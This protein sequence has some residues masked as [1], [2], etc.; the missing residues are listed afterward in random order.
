MIENIKEIIEEIRTHGVKG[1][2][3]FLVG[4]FLSFSPLLAAV[5]LAP[6]IAKAAPEVVRGTREAVKEAKELAREIRS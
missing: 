2:G 5:V 1:F 3:Y 4:F 6:T